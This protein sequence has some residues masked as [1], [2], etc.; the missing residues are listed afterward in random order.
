[1]TES[2]ACFDGVARIG[3]FE[4]RTLTATDLRAMRGM[5]AAFASAFDDPAHYR[6]GEPSDAYLAALLG[7]AQFIAVA[8]F[9]GDEVVGGIAAYVLPKFEQM[10]SE[11][12]LYD[13]AVLERCRRRG[14]AT[15]MIEHLGR[16]AARYGAAAVYV[17]AH[18]EDEPAV[19]LYSK[20]GVR[21]DV[22][23][24][25]IAMQASLR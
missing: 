13:L 9:E 18:P 12:Y 14:I 25:D 4:I 11:I 17:Q 3:G 20:L 1:M 2:G 24:F 8:A 15:A 22:L 6:P 19:R 21:Q 23:H 5:L 10:R 16:I 7:G